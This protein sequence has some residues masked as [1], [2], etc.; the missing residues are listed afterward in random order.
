MVGL[1][2]PM[3]VFKGKRGFKGIIAPPGF[4]VTVQQKGW[5]DEGLTLRFIR[6]IWDPN[7]GPGS[8]LMWDSFRNHL[9][10]AVSEELEKLHIH[11]VV[12]PGGYTSK[13]Q[14]LDVSLNEPFKG[15]LRKCWVEYIAEQVETVRDTDR[16]K[17]VPK[18]VVVDW[19]IRAWNFLKEQQDIIRKSFLVI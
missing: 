12:I 16:V 14:P 15:V 4:I 2:P 10:D 6:D 11:S 18:Q 9:A 3:I 7:M 5:M 13:S 8:L 17:T 19:I 1:L